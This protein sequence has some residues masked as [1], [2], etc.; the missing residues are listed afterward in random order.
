M[1]EKSLTKQAAPEYPVD[2]QPCEKDGIKGGSECDGSKVVGEW[3]M[4]LLLRCFFHFA[5]RFW[6]HTFISQQQK[7]VVISTTYC[8]LCDVSLF[9]IICACNFQYNT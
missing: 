3:S 5:R 9:N 8:Y 6:N 1:L 7:V 4:E 2:P